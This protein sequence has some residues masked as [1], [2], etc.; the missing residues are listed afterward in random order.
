MGSNKFDFDLLIYL[1]THFLQFN[2]IVAMSQTCHSIRYS[3]TEQRWRTTMFEFGLSMP[4]YY[5]Q[6]MQV[7]EE[8]LPSTETPA[9]PWRM[10][11]SRIAAHNGSCNACASYDLSRDGLLQIKGELELSACSS[12]F[13]NLVRKRISRLTPN[14]LLPQ[15]LLLVHP[16]YLGRLVYGRRAALGA[17]EAFDHSPKLQGFFEL[18]PEISLPDCMTVLHG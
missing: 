17:L 15:T 8:Q 14:L 10:L 16:L 3:Y 9:S 6:M 5:R 7:E 12:I 18:A 4:T 13:M 2:S 11:A 1:T